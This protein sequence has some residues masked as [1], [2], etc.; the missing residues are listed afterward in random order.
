MSV[1]KQLKQKIKE[2]SAVEIIYKPENSELPLANYGV[3]GLIK[4]SEVINKIE[5]FEK[6]E[7]E[8]MKNYAERLKTR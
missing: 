5:A 4:R 8:Q 6:Q 7:R 3:T 2:I 1:L